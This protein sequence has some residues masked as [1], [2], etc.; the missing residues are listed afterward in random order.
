M[1]GT[2]ARRSR[3]SASVPLFRFRAIWT[4]WVRS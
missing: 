3:I 1:L 4:R 2:A